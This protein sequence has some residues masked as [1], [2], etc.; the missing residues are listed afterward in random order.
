MK[1]ISIFDPAMCCST[2]VCG[3]S[4]DSELL[5][6]STVI[7]NLDKKGI[8]VERNGLSTN[9]EIFITNKTVN[10]LLNKEGIDVLPITLVDGEVVKTKEYLTNVEFSKILDIPVDQLQGQVEESCC[11]DEECCDDDD[12]CGCGC[13]CDDEDDDPGC[14]C[15]DG[16]C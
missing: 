4:V 14:S 3:P 12:S 16:C 7:N 5:R 15:G 10:D 6:V 1:K 11:D 13:G 9:P 8:K 2:G